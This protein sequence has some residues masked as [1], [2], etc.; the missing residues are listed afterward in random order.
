MK[1]GYKLLISLAIPQ[2]VGLVGALFTN[3]GVSSWYLTL[4]KSAL[5]PPSWIFGP[6][7][8][9]L[10]LM[11][12]FAF[13]LVWS[14]HSGVLE[15]LR[16]KKLGMI[17]WWVQLCL[18]G[19][20]S[21]FFFSLHNPALALV[22]ITLLWVAIIVTIKLFYKISRTAAWLLLPYLLWVSFAMYLNYSI[23]ALN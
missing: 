2:M 7:W 4:A 5:N 10:Y 9:L 8:T 16:I 13:Y 17:S 18:N 1:K 23:W 19:V 6:V 3:S 14:N 22:D 20:W 21:I 15:N 12:G 11:M